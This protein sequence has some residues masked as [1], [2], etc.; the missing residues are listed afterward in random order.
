MKNKKLILKFARRLENFKLDEIITLSEL[1]EDEVKN[2]LKVLIDEKQLKLN[3]DVYFYIYPKK[4]QKMS[5]K[6][7]LVGKDRYLWQQVTL[8]P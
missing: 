6:D 5:R 8:A 4:V 2:L 7:D 3:K 1:A